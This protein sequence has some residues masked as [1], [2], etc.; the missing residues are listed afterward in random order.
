MFGNA[1]QTRFQ[2]ASVKSDMLKHMMLIDTPGIL[3]GEKQVKSRGY[4]FATVT[5]FMADKVDMIILMFDTSKLD[6]SDEYKYVMQNLRGNEEK[7]RCKLG[8]RARYDS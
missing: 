4:D 5:R 3:S 7:V 8:C 1:F 2:G 6:I